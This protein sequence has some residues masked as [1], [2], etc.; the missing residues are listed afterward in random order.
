MA[1]NENTKS[2]YGWIVK[3]LVA[4]AAFFIILAVLAHILLGIFTHHGKVIEVPDMTNM[5]VAEAT[6]LASSAGIRIEVVDSTYQRG[7]AKGAVY[8]QNPSAG[9]YVKSGRR[10]LLTINTVVPKKEIVPNLVGLSMRQAQA[11][12]FSRGLNVG[13]LVYVDDIATNNVLQQ[14]YRGRDITPGAKVDSGSSIDLVVGLSSDDNSTFIPNVIGQKYVNAT[15]VLHESSLNVGKL[16]FD[17]SVKNFS[18]SISAVVYRQT[19]S[20]AQVP[21]IKGSDVSL[22]LTV[23]PERMP[24]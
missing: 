16:T 8:R 15:K 13:K 19:P 3:N 5:S 21:T 23:D 17:A 14:K 4:A 11:E 24:K 1:E 6:S 10:I 12:L 7:M 22:Y 2:G 18:D 9:S 20:A